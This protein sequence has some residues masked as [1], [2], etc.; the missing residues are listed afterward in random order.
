MANLRFVEEKTKDVATR[1]KDLRA[2]MK[3]ARANVDNRD[4]KTELIIQ[5]TIQYLDTMRKKT[6]GHTVFVYQ[7][8]S[9]ETGT[10]K[11]I[12]TLQE[13]GFVVCCPRIKDGEMVAVAYNEAFELSSL[14]IREPIGEQVTFSPHYAITP[15][16]AVDKQ[17]NRLGYGKGYYD[18]YFA[19]HSATL[20]IGYCFARQI[21]G[22][23]PTQNS[24][25]TLQT[26]ITEN[27]VLEIE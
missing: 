1:K 12:E 23:V 4:V 16:L 24:D 14:G 11:L 18:A 3:E 10:D 22:K 27:G 6:G 8:F 19:L 13:K 2:Y 21:I 5:N 25:V 17:G 15:L 9:T 20:R 26:I 7:S